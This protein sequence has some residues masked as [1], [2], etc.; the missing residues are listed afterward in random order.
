MIKFEHLVLARPEQ[1]A[2]IVEGM[3]NPMNSWEKSDSD[4]S[5]FGYGFLLGDNDHS[6]MRR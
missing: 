4:N 1:M 3:R 6:L 5:I 2:F